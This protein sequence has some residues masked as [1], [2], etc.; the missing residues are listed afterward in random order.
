MPRTN[1]CTS[2]LIVLALLLAAGASALE[3]EETTGTDL[4]VPL[5]ANLGTVSYP[6]SGA[7]ELGQQYF[8]QGL[9]LVYAFWMAEARRSFDE[10]ARLDDNAMSHWG[11]ALA[12]GP[13]LN[14]GSPPE[15]QLETA[16]E[17]ISRARELSGSATEKE[18][19]MIEALAVRYAEDP[20][21]DREP[22]DEAWHEKARALAEKYPDDIELQV[23]AAAS[24]MNTTRWNYW[25][26]DGKPLNDGTLWLVEQIERALDMDPNHPGAIHYYIHG[27]EASDNLARA[28]PHARNLPRTMPGAA[29][30][31]HMGAHILI[32]TGNYD[33]AADFNLDAAAVDEL[34]IGMPDQEGRYPVGSYQHNVHFAWS[35]AQFEG[36]SAVALQQAYKLRDKVRV[37]VGPNR[38]EES[39]RPQ[40]FLSIPLF[41]QARFGRWNDIMSEPQPRAEYLFET[42]IWHYV[43]GLAHSATGDL[44]AAREHQTQV[45]AIA[46]DENLPGMG[47]VSA[48]DMLRLA[49]TALDAD[50]VSRHDAPEKAIPLLEEA[51]NIQDNLAYTEPPPWYMPMRQTLGAVLLEAG[52]PDHAEVAFREDLRDWPE[53]GW[54]LFGL[55]E[56]LR[57]QGKTD[58]ANRVQRRFLRAWSRA[59]IVLTAARF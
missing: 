44:E 20:A 5:H 15:D 26:D 1:R 50:I 35:A 4:A 11:R 9:R 19:A 39:S 18:Q 43:R 58:E 55:L 31:V 28:V 21:S 40:L 27:V 47:R 22:L 46:A 8:D 29:H 45:A 54:S 42:A 36:R 52:Q 48:K 32:Q 10:A 2:L 14:Q 59:D 13:Y 16:W 33:E 41:A 17:A 7:S 12:Y 34:Y 37:Q 49:A 6:V 23:L 51:I 57:A 56:S 25:D 38:I 24:Y 53:N 30:L 3:E